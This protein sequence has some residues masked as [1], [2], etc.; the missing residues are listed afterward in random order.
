LRCCSLNAEVKKARNVF[1]SVVNKRTNRIIN[2][3]ES[4]VLRGIE[5]LA[6]D[7]ESDRKQMK[8][9][10]QRHLWAIVVN[11]LLPKPSLL[12]Y[13][14]H[15]SGG[16]QISAVGGRLPAQ[17]GRAERLTTRSRGAAVRPVAAAVTNRERTSRPGAHSFFTLQ[18]YTALYTEYF[19][20]VSR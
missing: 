6:D 11:R 19:L 1:F 8:E 2:R 7:D 10:K 12:M 3:H 5:E 18:R 4:R 13:M 15:R 14:G 20:F 9:A 17:S 16:R